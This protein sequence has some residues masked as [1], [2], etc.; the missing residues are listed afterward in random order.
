MSSA[1]AFNLT[2]VEFCRLEMLPVGQGKNLSSANAFNLDKGRI[3]LCGNAFDWTKEKNCHL[4]IIIV[5]LAAYLK[6]NI[7][8]LFHIF[9]FNVQ[10][11]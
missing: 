4:Q 11:I 1:N 5:T 2:S 7:T 3:L 8:A 10:S 6:H 9:F